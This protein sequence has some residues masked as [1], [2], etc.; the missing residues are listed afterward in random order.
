[1]KK[2]IAIIDCSIPINSRNQ[3]IIDSIKKH[4]PEHDIHIITWNRENISLTEKGKY[5]HAF[6]RL[7]PYA[8]VKAKLIGM[9]GFKKYIRQVLRKISADVIIAS[10]WSN[11]ILCV[12][13]KHQGQI[14]IYENLDVPTGG[15]ITRKIS[16]ALEGLALSK[17]DVI[18]HA[19]RFFKQLYPTTIPQIILENKPAFPSCFQKE[20]IHKPLIISFI[21]SVRYKEILTKLVEAVKNDKRFQLYIHGS[22]EDLNFMQEYC[23]NIDNICFTG[24]YQYKDVVSLYHQSD[25]VWAAYPNKDF[26][27]VYAI[28]NKFHESLFVGVPCIY[29]NQTELSNLVREKKIGFVVNP[30]DISDIKRLF[31]SIY[32]GSIEMNSVKENML[33]FQKA[34]TTWDEDFMKLKKYLE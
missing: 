29:S 7:A 4:F 32:D 17:V 3:K 22:G 16:Q 27:V 14:L 20:G 8:D 11:L 2:T 30:Y 18:V 9:F 23:K 13:Q 15:L 10:H 33:A 34:E 25:V 19:S 12:G 28:S 21:G 1:M 31:T 26:N 24:K 5:F 6:N